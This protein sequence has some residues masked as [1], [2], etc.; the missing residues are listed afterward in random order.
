MTFLG[1]AMY[2]RA[3]VLVLTTIN[4]FERLDVS[5]VANYLADK[6]IATSMRM[7]E[8]KDLVYILKLRSAA[9]MR[10]PHSRARDV[11]IHLDRVILDIAKRTAEIGT[12]RSPCAKPGGDEAAF[13][14]GHVG[15]GHMTPVDAPPV[16]HVPPLEN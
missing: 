4:E 11:A 7:E 14:H 3:M 13:L 1:D 16:R 15:H 5:S 8:S 10:T 9:L 6:L 2:A 12:G